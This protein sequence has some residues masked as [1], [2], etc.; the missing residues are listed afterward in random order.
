MLMH[1]RAVGHMH[2]WS[3]V[4][5][6]ICGHQIG[7]QSLVRGG[8]NS[9]FVSLINSVNAYALWV[10]APNPKC[11]GSGRTSGHSNFA[12]LVFCYYMNT[13]FGFSWKKKL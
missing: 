5:T 3:E 4:S 8:K 11:R 12:I 2:G 13:V 7:C 10:V 9:S 1:S 6:R